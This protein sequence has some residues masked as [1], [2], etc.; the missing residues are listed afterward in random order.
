MRSRIIRIVLALAIVGWLV[1]HAGLDEIV[2][3][4][5]H[6]LPL[7][8]ALAFAAVGADTLLRTLNWR[9]LLQAVQPQVLVDFWRLFAIY[10]SAALLGTF[11][12][13][14]AGTDLLRSGMSQHRAAA[15]RAVAGGRVPAGPGG[16]CGAPAGGHAAEVT[17]ARPDCITGHCGGRTAGLRGTALSARRVCR[18]GA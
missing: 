15:E 17:R 11:V 3:Q 1:V 2:S 4:M 13:S 6:V 16:L 5:R 8:V 7:P 10:L 9:Q 18:A 14:S 12:P